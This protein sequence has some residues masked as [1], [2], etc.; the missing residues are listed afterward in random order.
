[1]DITEKT[2]AD[3]AAAV[4]NGELTAE[5][6]AAAHFERIAKLDGSIKAFLAVTKDRALERARAVDLKRK[7]GEKLGVL[8]GVPVALKDNIQL[9]GVETTCGSNI[10]KGHIAAYSATVTERLLHADAVVVGKTNLDEFAMGSSTEN[11]AFQKTANPWDHACVPGGS[12]GGSAAAAAARF[13]AFS[14]GSGP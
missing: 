9:K 7:K 1:M 11:S 10:L 5:S 12:S 8:A 13:C 2:A 4:Q 3:I 6:V 14:L